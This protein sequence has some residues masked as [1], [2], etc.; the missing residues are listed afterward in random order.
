LLIQDNSIDDKTFRDALKETKMKQIEVKKLQ[1]R[2][3]DAASLAA[4][5]PPQSNIMALIS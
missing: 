2:T 4:L 1:K 5:Q 3:T